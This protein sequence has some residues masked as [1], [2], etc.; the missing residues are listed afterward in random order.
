MNGHKPAMLNLNNLHGPSETLGQRLMQLRL[1]S[2]LTQRQLADAV[3]CSS[4]TINRVE[5]DKGGDGV[6]TTLV[7]RLADRLGCSI[8]WLVSG[9]GNNPLGVPLD[10]V[11][12][13]DLPPNF[14]HMRIQSFANLAKLHYI[15][16]TEGGT[17][18]RIGDVLVID[19]TSRPGVGDDFA[20]MIDG[21]VQ[22]LRLI[23]DTG[24]L[25]FVETL[26]GVRM[27][28]NPASASWFGAIWGT[29]N[30]KRIRMA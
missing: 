10:G 16:L 21:K 22:V 12:G 14:D 6:S 24:D 27:R 15:L 19:S 20:A 8:D 26:D 9:V 2:G 1:L 5:G 3:D 17:G 23:T 11:L 30:G 4:A 29:I 28:F 25:A 7:K 13:G 18:Y